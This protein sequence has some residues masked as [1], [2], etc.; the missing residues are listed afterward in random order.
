MGYIESN[1]LSDE[2]IVYKA[3]LHWI[4]FGKPCALIVLGAVLLI[5]LPIAGMIVLAI[6]LIALIPPVTNYTTS[7]FG[8]P[9]SE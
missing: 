7:E 8:A 4:I 3:K 9:T 1:R 5:I 6:G 2:Q